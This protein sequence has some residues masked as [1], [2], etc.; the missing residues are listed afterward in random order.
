MNRIFRYAILGALILVFAQ[1][2][3]DEV[4][5][6]FTVSGSVAISD[7]EYWPQNQQVLF[8]LFLGNAKQPEY[9]Q[10]ITKPVASIMNFEIINVTKGSYI[11]KVYIAENQIFKAELVN[12]GEMTIEDNLILSNKTF[13]LNTYSRVQEQLFNSCLQCHGAST[14]IAA[15]LN[16]YTDKSYN[17]LVNVSSKNSDKL[18]V[19]PFDN[20]NSFLIQILMKD[21]LSFDHSASTNATSGDLELVK[22][23]IEKGAL[24]D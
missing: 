24:N 16:F 2:S 12:F 6:S 17:L 21:N 7:L 19:K 20:N 5:P 22:N 3:K 18:R 1:C 8:G 13:A 9:S 23:W 14:E 4:I 15:D 11:P 10:V